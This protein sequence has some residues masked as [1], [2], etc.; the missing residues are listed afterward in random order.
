MAQKFDGDNVVTL[1]PYS[2]IASSSTSTLT[3]G[4]VSW[5]TSALRVL[6]NLE[7]PAFVSNT[8]VDNFSSHLGRRKAASSDD[9]FGAK[10]TVRPSVRAFVSTDDLDERSKQQIQGLHLWKNIISHLQR[11]LGAEDTPPCLRSPSECF[12]GLQVVSS[13]R[14][15]LRAIIGYET[16]KDEVYCLCH[17]LV[18]N[19][20]I[21]NV[22]NAH[23]TRFKDCATYR[24]TSQHELEPSLTSIK[25]YVR[26][27][28]TLQHFTTIL[29][30]WKHKWTSSRRLSANNKDFPVRA[31]QAYPRPQHCLGQDTISNCR[32]D[33]VDGIVHLGRCK[34]CCHAS[35]LRIASAPPPQTFTGTQLTSLHRSTSLSSICS[36]IPKIDQNTNWTLYGYL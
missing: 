1:E 20:V 30:S 28:W 8:A 25:N 22:K 24:F 16:T 15:Y 31:H 34:C 12:V 35:N 5:A 19:N 27:K 32:D 9:I 29:K 21:E 6:L 2:P 26:S 36:G 4:K 11:T 33:S 3:P 14:E 18:L 10:K 17:K 13:I 7:N 23:S